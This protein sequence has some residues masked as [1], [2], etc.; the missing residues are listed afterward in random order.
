PSRS[1]AIRNERFKL[2]KTERASC[3]SSENPF[4]FYDLQP[5]LSNPV[6]LDLSINNLLNTN[7]PPLTLF[8]AANLLQLQHALNNILNSEPVCYGDGNLDK[9]VDEQDLDGVLRYWGQ[10]SVFDI[11]NDGTT[12]QNDLDCVLQNLGHNCLMNGPGEQ[13]K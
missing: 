8:Q 11:N 6:G 12:D 2:V 5:R 1:W 7:A 9:V 13:C 3:D 4:E 10:P